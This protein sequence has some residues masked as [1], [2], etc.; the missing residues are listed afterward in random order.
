MLDEPLLIGWQVAPPNRDAPW[1][2][3]AISLRPCI[4]LS[5]LGLPSSGIQDLGATSLLSSGDIW[6]FGEVE[7]FRYSFCR[8]KA[9]ASPKTTLAS[10]AAPR[11]QCMIIMTNERIR[12]EY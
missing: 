8:Q 10:S 4:W 2:Y 11:K 3:A 9:A 1:W 5:C 12:K 7:Q 6:E